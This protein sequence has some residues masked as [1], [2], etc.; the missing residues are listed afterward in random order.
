MM[1]PK[2]CREKSVPRGGKSMQI[3]WW[4]DGWGRVPGR[5]SSSA[6]VQERT[7]PR[8]R[9]EEG[10]GYATQVMDLSGYLRAMRFLISLEQKCYVRR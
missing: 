5:G 3:F 6:R 7:Q 10:L 1:L 9:L 4:G 8:Q 2:A